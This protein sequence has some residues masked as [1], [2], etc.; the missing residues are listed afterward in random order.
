MTSLDQFMSLDGVPSNAQQYDYSMGARATIHAMASP[1]ASTA[2]TK[3]PIG[4]RALFL[5]VVLCASFPIS[6][7]RLCG[8]L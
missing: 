8:C 6:H 3:D 4:D 5:V 2:A 7:S 1:A